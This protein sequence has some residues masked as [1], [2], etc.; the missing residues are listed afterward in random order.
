MAS[1]KTDLTV[2]LVPTGM[3]AGVCIWPWGVEIVPTR[4][5]EFSALCLISNEKLKELPNLNSRIFI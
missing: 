4:A 5:M 1:G 2:A 3:K